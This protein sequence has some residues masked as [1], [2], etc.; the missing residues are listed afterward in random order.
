MITKQFLGK[1]ILGIL[2]TAVICSCSKETEGPSPK[3]AYLDVIQ[4][5]PDAPKLNLKLDSLAFNDFVLL[6]GARTGY[7]QVEVGQ[8]TIDFRSYIPGKPDTSIFKSTITM[9]QFNHY[10][11]FL[12]DSFSKR[13]SIT[14]PDYNEMANGNKAAMRFIN[15]SPNSAPIS[16]RFSGTEYNFADSVTF[17][18]STDTR[19]IDPGVYVFDATVKYKL[20]P[21]DTFFRDTTIAQLSPLVMDAGQTYTIY[22]GGFY[23]SLNHKNMHLKAYKSK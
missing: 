2:L 15:L 21:T 14:F 11:V 18:S 3:Y 23:D 9:E 8:R 12:V 22:V 6:Y 19:V 17:Q 4:T 5:S 13:T 7:K 20:L 16:L 1:G 10:S